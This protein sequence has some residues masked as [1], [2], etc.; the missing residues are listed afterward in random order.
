MRK[1]FIENLPRRQ[2]RNGKEIDWKNTIGYKVKFVYDDVEGEVEIIDY[3]KL[4]VKFSYNNETYDILTDNFRRCNLGKVLGKMTNDFRIKLY[5]RIKD[6]KRDMLIVDKKYKKDYKGQ[7]KKYYKYKCNNCG[8]DEGWIEEFNL[9]HGKG[10]SCCRGYVVVE[11]INDIPSTDPWMVKYFQGG[12][13]EAK[14][15]T[16][17]SDKEIYPVCPDCGRV[18]D[19]PMKID[20]L[21]KSKSIACVCGD[22]ISYPE[23]VMSHVLNIIEPNYISQLSSKNFEWCNK[24]RYDFYLPTYNSIIE[25]HGEQHYRHTGFKRTVEEEQ[26]NDRLKKE[27]ALNNGIDNYIIIDCRKSEINY[28]KNNILN[29]KLSELYD[30]NNIDWN[31]VNKLSTNNLIKE[32]CEY[33]QSNSNLLQK[34]VANH[35]NI[36]LNTFRRYLEKG[37]KLGWYVDKKEYR[38]NN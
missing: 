14:K 29:S 5:S 12:Y 2:G 17:G 15:Y 21:R 8:W 23:K 28:I 11:G 34:E 30:L 36:C 27:L 26:E 9:L 32:V 10:C 19:K 31:K 38:R 33:Y 4:H 1:M 22:K 37:K 24:Y 3:E 16:K 18:K 20:T 6:T 7:N 13:D 35:F 25:V